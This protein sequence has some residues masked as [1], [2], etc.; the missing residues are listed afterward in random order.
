MGVFHRFTLS[1]FKLTS[2]LKL[3]EKRKT[4]IRVSFK[5]DAK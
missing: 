3:F 1:K 2:W 4:T 5:D